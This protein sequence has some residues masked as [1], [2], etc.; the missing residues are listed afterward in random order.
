ML[1]AAAAA[2][3]PWISGLLTPVR[4]GMA[5]GPVKAAAEPTRARATA[6]LVNILQRLSYVP[7]TE[8][9]LSTSTGCAI[10]ESGTNRFF[11][12]HAI[13]ASRVPNI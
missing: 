12:K 6:D 3:K 4:R 10:F 1:A 11:L 5:V 8:I 2:A 9:V 7:A 13:F